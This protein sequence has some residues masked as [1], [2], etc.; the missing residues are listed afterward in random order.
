MTR[1][2]YIYTLCERGKD[3]V[4]YVGQTVNPEQRLKA[5]V[6]NSWL[7]SSRP[8]ERWIAEVILMGGDIEMRI[9]EECA[10]ESAGDREKHWI[11][12]HLECGSILT[13]IRH[14]AGSPLSG[15]DENFRPATRTQVATYL[16]E[17]YLKQ[18]EV[19][20]E[21]YGKGD[22]DVLRELIAEKA[23]SILS[24]GAVSTDERVNAHDRR[25]DD[26][27]RRLQQLE[28]KAP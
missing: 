4:R 26:L 22:A 15:S 5:H 12:Y 11:A 10:V 7:E 24:G 27:E 23:R 2:V 14:G 3:E 1:P 20:K 13:N 25:L 28:N 9:I 19:V 6:S 16:N 8:K 18:W 17:E 21:F